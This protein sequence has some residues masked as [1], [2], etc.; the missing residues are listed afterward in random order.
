M[1]GSSLEDLFA[2]VY[3]Q[4]GVTYMIS[5]KASARAARSHILAKSALMS[6]LM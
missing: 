1:T 3:E 4:N 2:E 6:L 5:G